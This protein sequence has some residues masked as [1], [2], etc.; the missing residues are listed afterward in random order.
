M[1]D[2]NRKKT[3]GMIDKSGKIRKFDSN[4]LG[5]NCRKNFSAKN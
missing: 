2:D 5:N 1:Y 3:S 4:S